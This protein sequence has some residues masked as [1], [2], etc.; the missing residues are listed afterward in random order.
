LIFLHRFPARPL[1]LTWQLRFACRTTPNIFFFPREHEGMLSS[2]VPIISDLPSC[3]PFPL[4]VISRPLGSLF[5]RTM[6]FSHQIFFPLG[7]ERDFPSL[8]RLLTPPGLSLFRLQTQKCP[9]LENFLFP[10]PSS[11]NTLFPKEFGPSIFQAAHE[12]LHFRLEGP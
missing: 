2:P 7:F 12:T 3:S 1:V 10:P 5:R 11:I 4:N 6:F 9:Y 8:D